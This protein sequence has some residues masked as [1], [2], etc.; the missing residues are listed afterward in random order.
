MS[1]IDDFWAP[2]RESQTYLDHRLNGYTCNL[3][4]P[5]WNLPD[6]AVSAESTQQ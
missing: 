1:N 4:R 2:E 5:G 3:I 6:R